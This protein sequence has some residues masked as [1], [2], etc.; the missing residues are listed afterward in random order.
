MCK[1]RRRA[2]LAG[3]S[4]KPRTFNMANL[5][6]DIVNLEED[7]I[8]TVTLDCDLEPEYQYALACSYAKSIGET[9]HVEDFDIAEDYS[10]RAYIIV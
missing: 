2:R 1:G 5:T 7:T 10:A 8:R 4:T 3:S 6:L 9:A